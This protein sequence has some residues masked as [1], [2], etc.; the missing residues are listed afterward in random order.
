MEAWV[1]YIETTGR[2]HTDF[3]REIV[4]NHHGILYINDTNNRHIFRPY[5]R[6]VSVSSTQHVPIE[7]ENLDII[8]NM[9]GE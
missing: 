1:D 3:C 7:F 8:D 9:T 2:I 6:I 5:S 4:R